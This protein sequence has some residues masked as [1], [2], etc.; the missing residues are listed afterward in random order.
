ML[1]DNVTDADAQ[2]YVKPFIS[3]NTWCLMWMRLAAPNF[4]SKVIS[5]SCP[6]LAKGGQEEGEMWMRVEMCVV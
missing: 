6:G 4:L 1:I 2:Y 5:R 3:Q